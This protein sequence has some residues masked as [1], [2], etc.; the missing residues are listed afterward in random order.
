MHKLRD[1]SESIA[2]HALLRQRLI[3]D[4]YL[5]LQNFFNRQTLD[6]VL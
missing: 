6:G 2:N 5:Y 4:G 1:S 3:E